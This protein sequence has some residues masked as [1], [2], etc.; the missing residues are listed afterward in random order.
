MTFDVTYLGK[1]IRVDS[2]SVEVEVSDEIP[3]AAPIV[4]GRLYKIGQIGTFV[5]LPVGNIAIFGVVSSVSNTPSSINEESKRVNLGS[6]FLT[7]QLIG[8]KVGDDEFE[9]GVGTNPTINDEVHLVV[10]SDLAQIYGKKNAGSIEIGKHSAS[11]NLSVYADLHKLV[12][13]HCAIFDS[14]QPAQGIGARL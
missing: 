13:R 1:V 14:H 10:E 7:V 6:R 2:G 8:E 11:E 5:K 12:L 4:K 3:S 9:K